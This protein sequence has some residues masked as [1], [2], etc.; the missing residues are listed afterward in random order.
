MLSFKFYLRLDYRPIAYLILQIWNRAYSV[1]LT[2]IGLCASTT[3]WSQWVSLDH[4]DF[5]GLMNHTLGC[6]YL[7]QTYCIKFIVRIINYY[8][9]HFCA[10]YWSFQFGLWRFKSDFWTAKL[11]TVPAGLNTRMMVV[12]FI[13]VNMAGNTL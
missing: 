11:F 12:N 5:I 3:K 1:F 7:D 10:T 6:M 8:P 4:A 2:S 9:S 13:N